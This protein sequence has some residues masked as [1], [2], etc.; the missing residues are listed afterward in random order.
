MAITFVLASAIATAVQ[1]ADPLPS[2]NDGAA[3]RL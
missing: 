3:T 1:A 2:R